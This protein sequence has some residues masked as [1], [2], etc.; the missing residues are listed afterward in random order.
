MRHRQAKS[1]GGTLAYHAVVD[2]GLLLIALLI[3]AFVW[4]G[5]KTLPQLGRMFG[6]G[7]RAV[8][9]EAQP[10]DRPGGDTPAKP[11]SGGR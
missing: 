11:E 2:L 9:R 1:C 5:P 3:V 7:I 6:E 10:G 4:R 8:R